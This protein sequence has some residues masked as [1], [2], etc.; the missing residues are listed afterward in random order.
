[1]GFAKS[2]VTCGRLAWRRQVEKRFLPREFPLRAEAG[3]GYAP[4]VT[5]SLTRAIASWAEAAPDETALVSGNLSFTRAEWATRSARLAGLLRSLGLASDGRVAILGQNSH[6]HVES[7]FAAMWAGGIAVPLNWRLAVPELVDTARDCEPTVVFADAEFADKAAA[8]AAAVPSIRTV[9]LEADHERLLAAAQPVPDAGRHDDDV[10]CLIYTGGTTGRAKGVMLTHTNLVANVENASR[11][12]PLGRETVHLHCGA[13]F[14]LS[15]LW[16]MFAVT[17]LGGRHVLLPRFEVDLVLDAI[18]AQRVS[19]AA[20]VPTMMAALLDSPRFGPGKLESLRVITYGASP[21]SE[22]LLERLMVALPRCGLYQGYGMTETSPV[23]TFSTPADHVPGH[24]HLRSCGRPVPNV[25]VRIAD[26]EDRELPAGTVG[27]VQLRGAT[28][29]KGYWRQPE[30]TAATLRGGWMR[31]ADAGYLDADGYLYIVDRLKDMVVTG[32]ENVYSSEVENAIASHPAVAACAVFGIPDA[33]WGEAVH[34]VV[35][36]REGSALT[37]AAIQEHC[38]A[39]IAAYKC[40]KSV[41]LR[42]EPLPLSAVNKVLKAPL[43][44]KWW[45]GQERHVA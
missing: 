18:E 11:I 1:M 3:R 24:P 41:E 17:L 13:L 21:V 33:K 27:E 28:V 38:R 6:R 34:A 44:A 23:V 15:A 14:H 9:V 10:A 37:A 40:P 31:T 25:E 2:A 4:R 32:G 35:V 45:A 16:R 30:L 22:S 12:V 29:M 42:S 43:R 39:R 36:P 7:L 5:S 26:A 19:A 8:M 20:F